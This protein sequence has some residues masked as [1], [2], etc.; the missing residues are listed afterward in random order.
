[1]G[2]NRIFNH[3]LVFKFFV[4][5]TLIFSVLVSCATKEMVVK[6]DQREVLRRRIEEYWKL[7][8]DGFSEKAYLYLVPAYREKNSILQYAAR[9][10]LVKYRE[11]EVMEIEVRGDEAN[12]LV[13][14]TYTLFLKRVSN[15]ELKRIEKERWARIDGIWYHVPEGFELNS[16]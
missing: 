11:A 3:L 9:F 4:A 6:E 2:V 14:V 1:M 5:L 12:S 16:K 13:N 10:R 15:K 8:I 7:N